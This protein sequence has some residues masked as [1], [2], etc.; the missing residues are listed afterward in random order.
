MTVPPNRRQVL[1]KTA[2]RC[3]S[4]RV[5]AENHS[6]P[7]AY[8]QTKTR[9]VAPPKKPPSLRVGGEHRTG[10]ERI[11]TFNPCLDLAPFT[12][13]DILRREVIEAARWFGV[14][15]VHVP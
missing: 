10:A 14:L 5:V 13:P 2:V 8:T 4:S 6:D 3:Q 12:P 15:F 11:V 9:S 7:K 1:R